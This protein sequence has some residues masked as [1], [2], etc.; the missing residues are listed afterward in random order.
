MSSVYHPH[1]KARR[2]VYMGR[3]IIR[4]L[5]Q[6]LLLLALLSVA[7]FLLIHALPGGPEQVIFNPRLSAAGRAAIRARFGLDQPLPV[8]YFKWLLNALRGDF[9]F[10]FVTNQPV[11]D[12]INER[13][14]ATL[15][16]FGCALSL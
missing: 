6:A 16:L 2:R 3:Y 15:E 11:S 4:R 10:S 14:P 9:G 13:F 12:L 8:Q 5:L 7:M 1:F